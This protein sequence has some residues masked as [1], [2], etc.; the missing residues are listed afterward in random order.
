MNNYKK[1]IMNIKERGYTCLQ[2][3][4]SE[5]QCDYLVQLLEENYE[6]FHKQYVTHRETNHKL[7]HHT[8]EKLVYNL[9]NKNLA[10]CNLIN[11][12]EV[13]KIVQAS[14]QEGSYKNSEPYNLIQLTGR[15]PLPGKGG[16]QLHSDSRFPS[17]PYAMM[18]VVV[19]PL[20][21]MTKENGATRLVPFSHKSIEFPE[22]G[23]RYE[24]EI[25]IEARKG[26]ALIYNASLWH[27][28]SMN[29]TSN[30]RWSVLLTYARWWVK[31]RFDLVNNTPK[32]I[33]DMLS[34][35]QLNLLGFRST[36]P[37]DEFS[38]LSG[39][40]DFPSPASSYQLPIN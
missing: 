14:L 13:L 26:S 19:I 32:D 23:K 36:P 2:N 12:P 28:G 35:E 6:K 21:D 18:M 24:D 22:D 29:H 20:Q 38:R 39:R 16:Q 9:H 25:T 3:V 27:G 7:N 1:E 34:Q 31:P 17:I 37:L 40:S 30:S 4:V 5:K 8:N 33:Y 11:L 15:S 10:F